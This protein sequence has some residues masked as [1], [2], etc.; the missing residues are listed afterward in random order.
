MLAFNF[1]YVAFPV[2]AASEMKWSVQHT[3]AFFS[4]MSFCMVVVQGPVLS[5]VSK[6]WKAR[7]L[8]VV[9][10]LILG[11]GFLCLVPAIGWMAFAGAVLIA[12]GNGLMW[13]SVVALLSQ[14][15]GQ[16]Q[17]AVQGL[18]GSIGAAASILGLTLAGIL[19]DQISGWLFVISAGCIFGVV[20]LSAWYPRD[21]LASEA[22]F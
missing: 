1:F 2:Q 21:K 9:G 4:V 17:G 22:E 20:V 12:V 16:Q 13:A 11:F 5:R 7:R 19:Y 6:I 14:A 10:S 3:G 8:V 15:A 18:A